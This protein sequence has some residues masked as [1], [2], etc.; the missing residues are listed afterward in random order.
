MIHRASWIGGRAPHLTGD[1][2]FAGGRRWWTRE[3]GNTQAWVFS[4]IWVP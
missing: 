4:A 3:G 2:S 1:G